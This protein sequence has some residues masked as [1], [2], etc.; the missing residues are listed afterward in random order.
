MKAKAYPQKRIVSF[1]L[2]GYEI[3]IIIKSRAGQ[4][5]EIGRE[6]QKAVSELKKQNKNTEE[7]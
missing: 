7:N 3:T 4:A 5:R 2:F 1:D 6:I